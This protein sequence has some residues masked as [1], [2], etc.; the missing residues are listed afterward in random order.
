MLKP[1]LPLAMAQSPQWQCIA[2]CGACCRL[3]PALR[4]DALEA[5]DPQ[6]RE[7]YLAMV[8]PDGWCIHF[9]TGGRRCRVYS[10]RPDFCRVSNLV[11]LFAPDLAAERVASDP[12]SNDDPQ[13]WPPEV[14]TLAIGCCTD[15]IRSEYGGRGKVMRRFQ[16]AI[17]RP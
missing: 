3:D 6:Q 17:R 8:G 7:A 1:T 15:Q 16:R 2:G 13:I 10:D 12:L 11:Q 4:E 14:H 9:D 5:L